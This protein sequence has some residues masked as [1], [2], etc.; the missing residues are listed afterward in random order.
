MKKLTLKQQY[1]RSKKFPWGRKTDGTARKKPGR[2]S[3]ARWHRVA[4]AA[5]RKKKRQAVKPKKKRK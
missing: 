5:K 1:Q 2:K 4:E 3:G